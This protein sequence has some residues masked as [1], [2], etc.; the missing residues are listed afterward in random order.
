[1][2]S[3]TVPCAL[4]PALWFST[5]D[6]A[7]ADAKALCRGCPQRVTCLRGALE[8]AEPWGVWG[9]ELFHRGEILARARRQG[10]TRAA[11]RS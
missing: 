11:D 7:V 3:G 5:E 8:R 9:G 10:R 2:T 4:D 1:M 6:V